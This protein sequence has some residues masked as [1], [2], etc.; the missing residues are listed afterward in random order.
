[1]MTQAQPQIFSEILIGFMVDIQF[2]LSVLFHVSVQYLIP[3]LLI[4]HKKIHNR[5]GHFPGFWHNIKLPTL[6]VLFPKN[7]TIVAEH[8]FLLWLRHFSYVRSHLS[9]T[10]LTLKQHIRWHNLD[11]FGTLN[12]ATLIFSPKLWVFLVM[13][14]L[15]LVS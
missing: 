2:F 5:K 11:L 10:L 6:E 15:N 12:L 3:I 9:I 4:F 14:L 7:L 1:M 13:Y 8:I